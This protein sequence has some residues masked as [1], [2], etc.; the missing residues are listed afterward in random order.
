M[1][2]KICENHNH[3]VLGVSCKNNFKSFSFVFYLENLV[4]TVLKLSIL[5]GF[6]KYLENASD[7]TKAFK[8]TLRG[9]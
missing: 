4:N 1:L 8:A 6:V 9:L 3:L 2:F 5:K 7:I